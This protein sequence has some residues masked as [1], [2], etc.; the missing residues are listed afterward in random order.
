VKTKKQEE[1]VHTYLAQFGD[2]NKPLYQDI[3]AFLSALGYHPRKEKSSLSFKHNLHN[4]QLVK[5]GT[6][7]SKGKD[8]SP[9]FSLRFS[10]CRGYS[11]R[12]I[13]IVGAY[14]T[15]Y[16][17]RSAL[18]PSNKCHFCAGEADTHVYTHEFPDGERKAHCGAYAIEIPNIT[19]DD[20]E[21]IKQLLKKEHEYLEKHEV[22]RS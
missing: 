14:M 21:E 3:I 22:G 11:Q 8:A 6:R 1:L 5:M 2:E 12:F 17:T 18:C 13:D 16:P 19:A 9:S 15:K 10:A 20:L 4:K 7:V